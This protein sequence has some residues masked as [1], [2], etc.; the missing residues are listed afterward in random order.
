MNACADEKFARRLRDWGFDDGPD[1]E[2][3]L[4]GSSPITSLLAR[5]SH[6]EK[7]LC[8]QLPAGATL[9]V[10]LGVGMGGSKPFSRYTLLFFDKRIIEVEDSSRIGA[11]SILFDKLVAAGYLEKKA[12]DS[13]TKMRS[14]KKAAMV[15]G[16]TLTYVQDCDDRLRAIICHK[17]IGS[18]VYYGVAVR[19]FGDVDDH[20][21]G[22][23]L[24]TSRLFEVLRSSTVGSA[25][26]AFAKYGGDAVY[27]DPMVVIVRALGFHKLGFEDSK[28][29]EAKVEN[30]RSVMKHLRTSRRDIC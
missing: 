7:W 4:A 11:L 21:I 28:V 19:A 18:V 13:A 5:P 17:L 14:K 29:F 23:R 3:I 26:S 15:E 25:G 24:A 12:M 16:S 6:I 10:L 1:N 2:I 22:E 30:L 8:K 20:L 27:A 9:E